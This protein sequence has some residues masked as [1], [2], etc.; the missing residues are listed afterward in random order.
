MKKFTFTVKE[1]SAYRPDSESYVVKVQIVTEDG[2]ELSLQVLPKSMATKYPDLNAASDFAS[3]IR[4]KLDAS[5]TLFSRRRN[6]VAS[7]DVLQKAVKLDPSSITTAVIPYESNGQIKDRTWFIYAKPLEV[8]TINVET[9]GAERAQ[10]L[11]K[12]TEK[13]YVLTVD[14]DG[15]PVMVKKAE[16]KPKSKSKTK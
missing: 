14:A 6:A 2:N 4:G 1:A 5:E 7:N 13:G 10:E 12:T 16:E 3:V 9:R 8:I 11:V 15:K